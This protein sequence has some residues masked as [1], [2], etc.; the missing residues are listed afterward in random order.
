MIWISFKKWSRKQTK[1]FVW[2]RLYREGKK[3]S[4][5]IYALPRFSDCHFLVK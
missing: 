3:W 1:L 2:V 4:P 5:W